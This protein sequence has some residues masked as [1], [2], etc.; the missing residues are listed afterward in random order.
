MRSIA[1]VTGVVLVA[2]AL[3]AASC[4]K[5]PPPPPPAPFP[6][7][8]P[9][10]HDA[11]V[12][13]WLR[14]E[15]GVDAEVYRVVGASDY[16]VQVE[17]MRYHNGEPSSSPAV[18]TWS[19]NGFGLPANSVIRQI[20]RDAIDVGGVR[21][22]CWRLSIFTREAGAPQRSYWVS[23]TIPVQGLLKAAIV[24]KGEAD[25]VHAAKLVDWGPK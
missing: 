2:V 20:D 6:S 22:D 1:A 4:R 25:D 19:R 18:Q 9:P 17:V 21:Y 24:Q 14:L 11:Q 7:L 12:G 15:A 3:A 5:D 10:L 8:I 23:E 16:E 13:E